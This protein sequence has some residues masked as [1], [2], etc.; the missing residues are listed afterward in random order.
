MRRFLALIFSLLFVCNAYA[1]TKYESG[2]RIAESSVVYGTPDNGTTIVPL[3]V[4]DDGRVRVDL[5]NVTGPANITGDL[6]VS[7]N[8]TAN[9]FIANGTDERVAGTNSFID[10]NDQGAGK[11]VLG[12]SG[13]T[14]NENLIW[15]FEQNNAVYLNTSTGA[16]LNL[17]LSTVLRDNFYF[18][19][20]QGSDVK[21]GFTT[22][23]NDAAQIG[24]QCNDVNNH[25]GY[26]SIMES[27]D[28]GNGN[29]TTFSAVPDPHLRIYSSDNTSATDYIEFY[30]DQTDA[31][32]TVG[33]GNLNVNAPRIVTSTVQLGINT[34]ALT[35][36]T[37]VYNATSHILYVFNGTALDPLNE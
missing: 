22:V 10:F 17:N 15:D 29:R 26:L 34:T 20:G 35:E 36:G 24:L 23:G 1:V 27:D 16:N 30:H 8:I 25:P 2:N 33:S 31:N 18:Y 9:Q 7:G 6:N 37:L 12:G 21:I 11:I 4:S 13:G 3:N 5:S 14:N 32:I 28:M 19:L